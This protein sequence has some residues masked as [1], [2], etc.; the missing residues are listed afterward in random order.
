[1]ATQRFI[2]AD[3]FTDRLFGG[4]Q[5]A[6]LP[7]SHHLS[8]EAMQTLAREFNFSETVFIGA[9]DADN[10]TIPLRIFTPQCELPFAGHPTV[11]AAVVL[12]E[13][14]LIPMKGSE[15]SIIFREGVGDVPVTIR[16]KK[17]EH[18]ATFAQLTTARLP[19]QGDPPPPV[20]ILAQMLGLTARDIL[21]DAKH[22]PEAH[23]CGVPFVF[24][25][26]RDRQAVARARLDL[27]RW[28]TAFR[29]AWA[30]EIFIFNFEDGTAGI[31]I[32]ARMF[33]PSMNII[34]DAA[35]GSA[36]AALAGYLAARDPREDGTRTWRIAQGVEMGRPSRLILEIDSKDNQVQAVRVGGHAVIFARGELTIPEG[37]SR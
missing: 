24:I 4:N 18:E 2:I 26:L 35:T 22:R 8:D 25:P 17:N 6:V 16:R 30:R 37:R 36:C 11:G 29:D 28:E 3:V 19:E 34:E 31:D 33:A 13:E 21:H 1:M 32:H 12:A 9:P 10:G 7:D 27:A 20:E 23:S 5:L 14:G 15:V